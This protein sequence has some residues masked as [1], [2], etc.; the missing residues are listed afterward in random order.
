[1][2]RIGPQLIPFRPSTARQQG[3]TP[4]YTTRRS[5][6][7]A[8]LTRRECL[9]RVVALMALHTLQ[10]PPPRLKPPPILPRKSIAPPPAPTKRTPTT[11]SAAGQLTT[12]RPR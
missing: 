4:T 5:A 7:I 10:L 8:K 9:T 3:R 6:H 11:H 2:P 12:P 1:M